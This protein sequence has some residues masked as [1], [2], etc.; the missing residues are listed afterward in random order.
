MTDL[1]DFEAVLRLL[2]TVVA[3]HEDFDESWRT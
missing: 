3:D 2:A 1:P